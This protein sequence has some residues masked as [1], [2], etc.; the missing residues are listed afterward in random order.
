MI[1]ADARLCG[2]SLFVARKGHV[3]DVQFQSS[4]L[5]FGLNLWSKENPSY[6]QKFLLDTVCA[7]LFGFATSWVLLA[8]VRLLEV[9]LG[10][11]S[12]LHPARCQAD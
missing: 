3:S 12:Q 4:D 10:L 6:A 11:M 7:G 2:R 1:N 5:I 8:R 9:S